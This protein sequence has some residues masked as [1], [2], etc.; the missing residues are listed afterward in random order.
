VL[1][2]EDRLLARRRV[3]SGLEARAFVLE[4]T[5]ARSLG[6]GVLATTVAPAAAR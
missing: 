4:V 1:Q 6:G 5:L 3:V 2:V